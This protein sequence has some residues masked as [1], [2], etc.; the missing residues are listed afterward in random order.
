MN[1]KAFSLF[2]STIIFFIYTM[3]FHNT[4]NIPF[5]VVG[6]AIFVGTA[7]MTYRF[8]N[9]GAKLLKIMEV[10]AMLLLIIW[11]LVFYNVETNSDL[12]IPNIV[13]DNKYIV[14]HMMPGI[15]WFIIIIIGTVVSLLLM[16][17]DT[18]KLPAWITRV[19]KPVRVV[20]SAV[21]I[22]FVARQTYSPNIFLDEV[23]HVYHS[24]PYTNTIINV[25]WKVPYSM[26][27]TTIYGHFAI[28]YM[29]FV[30]ALHSLF[31]IMYLQ[32]IYIMI[33]VVTAVAMIS[34]AYILNHF[35]KNDVIY[36]LALFAIGE[37][38]FQIMQ[39]GTPAQVIPH[40]IV[41]PILITALALFENLHSLQKKIVWKTF[42]ILVLALSMVWSIEVGIVCLLAYT[43]YAWTTRI[44]D[45]EAFSVRKLISL[46]KEIG[47]YTIVP[48]MLAYLI[49]NIYNVAIAINGQWLGMKEYLFPIVSDMDYVSYLNMPIPNGLFSYFLVGAMFLVVTGIVVLEVIF[50]QHKQDTM[51]LILFLA[52]VLGLGLMLYYINRPVEGAMAIAIFQMIIVAAI[53]LQRACDHCMDIGR[54]WFGVD[55]GFIY[56]AMSGIIVF[57][58]F[59]MTFDG[60]Y[61][62]PNAFE[63]NKRTIWNYE[64][65]KEFSE[66]I[67]WN[68]PPDCYAFGSGVPE[69]LSVIDRNTMLHSTDYSDIMYSIKFLDDL[70]ETDNQPWFFCNLNSLVDMQEYYPNLTDNFEQHE[71]YKYAEYQFALYYHK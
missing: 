27:M 4:G 10:V 8:V 28:L 62:M 50:N 20:V 55:N 25:C 16:K 23:W 69:L 18:K 1:R 35:V 42:I 15:L 40:R 52:S 32:G 57:V 24:H 71:I 21:F 19:Q 38:F 66:T 9:L 53:L 7:L 11:M 33:A 26:K 49:V 58:L 31:G 44:W 12:Y 30:K 56:V 59:A 37:E 2:L 65:L 5:F 3:L 41:F 29:P 39:A 47:L 34:L 36:Y 48:Y 43:L 63:N 67:Y 17:L 70:K 60:F 68:V 6:C 14:R 64:D 51:R 13:S 61:S 54:N 46:A 45:G 22:F